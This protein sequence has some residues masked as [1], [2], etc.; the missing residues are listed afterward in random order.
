[1]SSDASRVVELRSIGV[2]RTALHWMLVML[3]SILLYALK[4]LLNGATHFLGLNNSFVC[5]GLSFGSVSPYEV[6]VCVRSSWLAG[7][8]G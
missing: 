5:F 8:A 4:V 7:L 6:I 1:M 3:V 2:K